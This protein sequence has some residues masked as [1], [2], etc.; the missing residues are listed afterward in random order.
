MSTLQGLMPGTVAAYNALDQYAQSQGISIGVANYGGIRTLSDTTKILQYRLDDYN[1]AMKAGDIR[2]DTTLNAFR[3]I[4]PFGSSY[5]NYG[6]AFDVQIIARPSNLSEA[7]ALAILG[8]FAPS[9]GLRWGGTFQNPDPPHFE[10][11]VTLTQAKAMYTAFVAS[12][13]PSAQLPPA[14]AFDL[15]SFLPGLTSTAEDDTA[16]AFD[17]PVSDVAADDSGEAALAMGPDQ[18]G[19]PSLLILGLFVAGLLAWAIRRKLT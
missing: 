10:V 17:V 18:S 6:A 2:P 15:P 8:R 16:A 13:D 9:I 11:A 1:A 19:T 14:S 7:Q 5:H 4:A 12:G 3:P